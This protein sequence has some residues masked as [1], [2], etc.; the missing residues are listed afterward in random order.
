MKGESTMDKVKVTTIVRD[1]KRGPQLEVRRYMDGDTPGQYERHDCYID[2]FDT[3]EEAD[4][5]IAEAK[6]A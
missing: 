3:P 1:S 6:N 2:E 4:D 5:F